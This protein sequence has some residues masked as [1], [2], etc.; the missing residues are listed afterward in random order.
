MLPLGDTAWALAHLEHIPTDVL[1]ATV[2]NRL[3]FP[4]F[5]A[6]RGNARFER[7]NRSFRPLVARSP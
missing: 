1:P 5:D 3:R 2:W 6:L 7:V 4:E